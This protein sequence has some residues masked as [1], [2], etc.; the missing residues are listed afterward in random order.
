MATISAVASARIMRRASL[1]LSRNWFT[2]RVGSPLIAA[3]TTGTTS[4]AY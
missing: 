2:A 1:A 4:L 3:M